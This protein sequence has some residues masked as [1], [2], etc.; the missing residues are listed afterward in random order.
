L[1]H[2][3]PSL[4]SSLATPVSI[5]DMRTSSSH[6]ANICYNPDEVADAKMRQ[7]GGRKGKRESGM[8]NDVRFEGVARG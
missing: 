2:N 6:S 5:S 7:E 8:P 3:V 1:I 4:L